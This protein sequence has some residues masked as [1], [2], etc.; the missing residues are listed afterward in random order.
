MNQFVHFK[1]EEIE[2]LQMIWR[3]F[4]VKYPKEFEQIIKSN[5]TNNLRFD[6]SHTAD[7][8]TAL[9]SWSC[10]FAAVAGEQGRACSAQQY[11]SELQARANREHAQ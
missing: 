6:R 9:C 11:Q 7:H 8:R 3:I 5:Q 4:K 1:L 2:K 10:R